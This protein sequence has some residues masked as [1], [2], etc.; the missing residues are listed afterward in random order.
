MSSEYGEHGMY[1]DNCHQ[2]TEICVDLGNCDNC[3]MCGTDN[4]RNDDQPIE[5]PTTLHNL[6]ELAERMI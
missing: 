6:S 1:C 2:Y 4:D 5:D 3:A